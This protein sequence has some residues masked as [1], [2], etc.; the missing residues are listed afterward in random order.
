MLTV[1]ALLPNDVL[2]KCVVTEVVLFSIV[3]FK[4]WHF[5]RQCSDTLEVWWDFSD[6]IILKNFLILTVKKFQSWSIF[7]EVKAHKNGAI[8]AHPVCLPYAESNTFYSANYFNL[9]DC[10]PDSAYLP[11]CFFTL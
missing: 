4:T 1:S 9:Y 3:A 11:C 6:S 5:T 8:L 10:F 7:A 2:L